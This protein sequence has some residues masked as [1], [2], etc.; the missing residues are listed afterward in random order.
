MTQSTEAKVE[1]KIQS[2]GVATNRPAKVRV[3]VDGKLFTEVVA[4]IEPQQ[5]ADGGYYPAVILEMEP[6]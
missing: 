2:E 3:Y 4:K 5:G 1:V 6:A